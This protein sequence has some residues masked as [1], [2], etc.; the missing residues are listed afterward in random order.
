VAAG[1]ADNLDLAGSL[2]NPFGE[3][4]TFTHLRV[5]ILAIDAPDGNKS[6]HF[7]P[8]GQANAWQGP[9]AGVSATDYII[10]SDSLFIV[11]LSGTNGWPVTAGT[12]DI[13]GIYNPGLSA[14]TYRIWLLGQ[15]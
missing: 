13:L 6:L 10:V 4:I 12:A 14:V 5:I 11:N 9:F 15:V 1:T 3:T 2:T 8:R 7:G